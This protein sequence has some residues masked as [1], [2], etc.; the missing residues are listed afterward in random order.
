MAMTSINVTIT[1]VALAAARGG[2]GGGEATPPS[3]MD[4]LATV[5]YV[6]QKVCVPMVVAVGVVGNILNMVVLTRRSM[7]NST[8]CYLAALAAFDTLYLLFSLTLSFQHYDGLDRDVLYVHWYPY[9]RVLC[10]MAANVSVLLTVTFTV[11]RYIG[12]CHPMRG[13]VLCTPQRAKILISLVAFLAT[14]CTLPELF[15]MEVVWKTDEEAGNTT[16]PK[17]QYT[18]LTDTYSYKIGYYWFF[19]TVFT[20]LPL[21]LLCVFNGILIRSLFRAAQLRTLMT[22]SSASTSSS[23]THSTPNWV[24]DRYSREQHWITKMLVTVVLVFILCQMPGAILVL[25]VA[26]YDLTSVELTAY[27][28]NQLRIAGNI[29]NLLIQINA[30]INF[31]L[32][33]MTSTKFRRVFCQ[34]LCLKEKMALGFSRTS[35][36]RNDVPLTS[37]VSGSVRRN[38]NASTSSRTAR[39]DRHPQL[40]LLINS[41]QA[42]GQNGNLSSTHA[43]NDQSDDGRLSPTTEVCFTDSEREL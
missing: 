29:T 9:G 33:S 35:T 41:S 30:S 40:R 26:N 28:W 4:T 2:E 42:K 14:A 23:S 21:L 32:Y 36:F 37:F 6:V 11:E 8:N 3:N 25:I 18:D 38:T 16:Y 22:F 10:D 15:E 17:W 24:G 19:V 39:P 31:I 1:T 20:F 12:V 13:R 5:R 7:T 43:W 34:T 27:D